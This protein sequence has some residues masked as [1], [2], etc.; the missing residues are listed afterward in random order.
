MDPATILLLTTQSITFVWL[1]LSEL[2]PF[3]DTP[4]YN[5]VVQAILGM[6]KQ[7]FTRPAVKPTI[8]VAAPVS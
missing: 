7:L 1:V 2:L 4:V 3:L 8:V 5:G 6:I